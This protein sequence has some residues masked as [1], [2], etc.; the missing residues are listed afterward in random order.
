M[1]VALLEL[2]VQSGPGAII[3]RVAHDDLVINHPTLKANAPTDD[4]Q[5]QAVSLNVD[6]RGQDKHAHG[7]GAEYEVFLQRPCL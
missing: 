5:F 1:L 3:R 2:F 7:Q 6:R 4:H